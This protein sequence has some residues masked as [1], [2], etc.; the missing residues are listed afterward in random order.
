MTLNRAYIFLG[1]NIER[2]KNYLEALRRIGGLGQ[3]RR[4]SSVYETAP[5]G[6]GC[7]NFYNG[8]VLLGT[9]LSALELK[10]ALREIEA[11][12]GRVR[13]ADRYAPR[14]IDLDLGLYNQERREEDGL[15]LPDPLI[16]RRP[17]MAQALAEVDPDYVHPIDGRTLAQIA[18][19]FGDPERYALASAPSKSPGRA[20]CEEVTGPAMQLQAKMTAQAKKLLDEISTGETYAR[21]NEIDSGGGTHASRSR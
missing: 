2:E 18:S 13:T 12:L 21:R 6:S 17:F 9:P 11:Q 14:T 10:R 19:S 4:A 1:T 8:A 7:E 16:L 3:L 20:P 15:R 5:I